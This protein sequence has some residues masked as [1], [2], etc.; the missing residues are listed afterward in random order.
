MEIG[1]GMTKGA[2]NDNTEIIATGFSLRF[3]IT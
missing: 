2:R 3:Q 1:A